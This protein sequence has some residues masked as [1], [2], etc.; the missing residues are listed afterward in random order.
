MYSCSRR[1]ELG[2]QS[3]GLAAAGISHKAAGPC[4][5]MN[6]NY[7]TAWRFDTDTQPMQPEHPSEH[8]VWQVLRTTAEEVGDVTVRYV[9]VAFPISSHNAAHP[10]TRLR[11]LGS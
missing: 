9:R 6:S 5:S 2:G 7:L 11:T 10:V 1:C 3:G 8:T 4:A